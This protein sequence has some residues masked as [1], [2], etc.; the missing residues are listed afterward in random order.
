MTRS[1]DDAEALMPDARDAARPDSVAGRETLPCLPWPRWPVNESSAGTA[2]SKGAIRA[3]AARFAATFVNAKSEAGERQTFWNEFFAIFDIDRKQVAAFELL[4]KRSTTGRHG[5]VDLLYPGHMGV[6]HKTAGQKSLDKAMAQLIDYLPSLGKAEHPWLLVACDFQRFQWRNLKNDTSGEFALADLPD[7]LDQFWWIAGYGIPHQRY[8]NEEAANMAA[9]R[10]LADIYD[11]LRE[12][13][14]SGHA[15]REWLTR[16]LFCLFADDTGVWDRAAFHA[17][18]AVHTRPDGSDLGSVIAHIFQI[19]NTAPAARPKKLDEELAQFSFINGDLFEEALPI[20]SCDP[21]I[22]DALLEACVFDWAAISPAIFGSMFQNVLEKPERRSLGAHYTTE[23]N[24]L[25]TIRPLFLDDLEAELAGIHSKP[26]LRTFL[27]KLRGLTFF[28]PACGC[29]N[30][31][32]IAYREIRRLETDALRRLQTKRGVEDQLLINISIDCQVRVDQ[33]FGMEIEEFPAKIARTALY[34]VDHLCNREV[35]KEFGQHFV[36]FPIPASPHIE[37]CNALRADWNALLPA[38]RASYVLGN[39]PFVGKKEQ[40]ASQKSDLAAIWGSGAG[41]LDYVTCWYSKAAEYTRGTTIRVGFVSTNSIAQ[42]EQVA[43][44]WGKLFSYGLKIHFAHSAFAWQSEASGKAH[45]H[46]VIIGFGAFDVATKTLF[47]YDK[48]KGE[49][50]AVPASNINPY[51]ADAPDVLVTRRTS[52]I[53]GAPDIN[54]GSMMIDRDRGASDDEGLIISDEER[55][56][57][58]AESPDLKPYIR[59]LVG[60]GEFI[61]RTVRWCLWLVNA[62]PALLRESHRLH[63]RIEHV[64]KYRL[65]SGRAQTKK[66]AATPS[67]FGEIRQPTS[68]YLLVPKVS[69]EARHYIPIGFLPPSV[70]ASGSA[71]V[72]ANASTYHFGILSSAMHNA[73]MR[74]VGGRLESRYQYSNQIIYNNYP[75][76]HPDEKQT[77]AVKDAAEAVLEARDAFPDATMADLYDP[78]AMPPALAKA[79]A[80]LDLAVER[81]YRQHRFTSDRARVEYLFGLFEELT[82]PLAPRT[83]AKATRAPKR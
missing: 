32:V 13:G 18:I 37:C 62:P 2:A 76:P 81:C 57:L 72:V 43:V 39:P 1:D 40:T 77:K 35:S 30:F 73:W 47:E 26:K 17:Y 9:T 51:L 59:K 10:L 61:N 14:Y 3:K 58:L 64:R 60:G 69:S 55:A 25:R 4:A 63:A 70:I 82:A 66:L 33:F 74:Y 46:V 6:E 7:N 71:L 44:L 75:W 36:R 20:P 48:P 38:S 80:A 45:V 5:F 28:D 83:V 16:I 27:D 54:Y 67:L 49:P 15:L 65:S 41:V 21:A 42:G 19:L 24:I 79:H 52:P 22:R 11:G 31:L 34:L 23:A 78:V 68:R 50:R 56:A 12:N 53:N 29:G 8:D